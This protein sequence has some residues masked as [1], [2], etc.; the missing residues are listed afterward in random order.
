MRS[1]WAANFCRLMHWTHATAAAIDRVDSPDAVVV[2]REGS[3]LKRTDFSKD[4][5]SD[6]LR[7][8]L[9]MVVSAID[10]Y[11]HAKIIAYV[12]ALAN[13]GTAMPPALSN[14]KISVAD[15]VKA[16]KY[17]RPMTVVRNALAEY[18]GYQSLQAPDQ[19][20]SALSW[21]GVA[22]FWN[23]VAARMGATRANVTS[24]LKAIVKRRNQIAHEGDLSQSKKARNKSRP[25]TPK[26]VRRALA[27]SLKLI[28]RAEREIN[29]QLP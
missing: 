13:K 6:L 25:L 10:A 11:F 22:D 26:E 8:S 24:G 18:L 21:L 5:L 17:E 27:F 15:F 3:R 2:L 9:V 23:Q 20:A 14:A 1:D 4:A 16:K 28:P 29:S 12:V 7:A 19:I